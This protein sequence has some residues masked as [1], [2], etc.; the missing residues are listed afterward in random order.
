MHTEGRGRKVGGL[1]IFRCL[2]PSTGFQALLW[3]T[4]YALV[5]L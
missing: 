5:Y 3:A 1:P 2:I 4:E